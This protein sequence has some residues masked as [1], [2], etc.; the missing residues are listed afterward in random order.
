MSL[1]KEKETSKNA[2]L[3]SSKN[4][5]MELDIDEF[6]KLRSNLNNEMIIIKF[7]AT[8]C[9]PC[10]KIKSLCEEWFSKLPSNVIIVDIDIDETMELYMAL[11]K[12]KMVNGIPSI[13][14]F[15]SKPTEENLWYI[16]NDSVIGGD[17]NGVESFF[18]RCQKNANVMNGVF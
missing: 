5:F 2:Q 16:P 7:G 12:Y 6:K 14:S 3:V 13:L 11:K 18:L 17:L 4:I 15:Y 9:G 10:K 1:S 8:W